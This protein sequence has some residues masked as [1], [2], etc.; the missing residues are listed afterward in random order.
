MLLVLNQI[1]SSKDQGCFYFIISYTIKKFL[2]RT[3]GFHELNS[4]QCPWISILGHGAK[5]RIYILIE[6]ERLDSEDYEAKV[7][8]I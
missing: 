3:C 2:Y 4:I 6:R 1:L 5:S 7:C 8:F